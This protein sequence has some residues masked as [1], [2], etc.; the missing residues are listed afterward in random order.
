MRELGR[1]TIPEEHPNY[2]VSQIQLSLV[3]TVLQPLPTVPGAISRDVTPA[4]A[5]TFLRPSILLSH[6]HPHRTRC[7]KTS[8]QN[9]HGFL[10]YLGPC[11]SSLSS[12]CH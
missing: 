9:L 6:E 11:P 7:P 2:T 3:P 1:S 12:L 4:T 5:S 8:C 10:E